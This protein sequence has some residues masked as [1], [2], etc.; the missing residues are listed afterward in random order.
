MLKH[1]SKHLLGHIPAV[2]P[3]EQR[4]PEVES[5]EYTLFKPRSE[6]KGWSVRVYAIQTTDY[7]IFRY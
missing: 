2:S 6:N 7:I 5:M 3:P 4:F 1:M